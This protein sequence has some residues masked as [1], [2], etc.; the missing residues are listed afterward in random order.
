M[1]CVM[2][3]PTHFNLYSFWSK[4]SFLPHPK[5][6]AMPLRIKEIKV[7]RLPLVLLN[8]YTHNM[9]DCGHI[10]HVHVFIFVETILC[11]GKCRTMCNTIYHGKTAWG[12]TV[13]LLRLNSLSWRHGLNHRQCFPISI[14]SSRNSGTRQTR[15]S[16]SYLK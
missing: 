15:V 3:R 13:L 16:I 2:I 10:V 6:Y 1:L 5:A 12:K 11:H 9:H 7:L 8:I 4:L 14:I